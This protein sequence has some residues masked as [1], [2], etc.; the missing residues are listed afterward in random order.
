MCSF[1]GDLACSTGTKVEISNTQTAKTA[2][3]KILNEILT[4]NPMAYVGVESAAVQ[5]LSYQLLV[6]SADNRWHD[7]LYSSQNN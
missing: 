3:I 1:W 2:L 5:R 7:V 6:Y 4:V